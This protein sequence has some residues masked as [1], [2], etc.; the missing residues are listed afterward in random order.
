MHRPRPD[1]VATAE[2]RCPGTAAVLDWPLW[3]ILRAPP[4]S[5]HEVFRY[6]ERLSREAR[7]QLAWW[8][9][10]DNFSRPGEILKM[11]EILER[12]A[13]VEALTCMLL[14]CRSAWIRG[15]S[16]S[17]DEWA[18]YIYRCQLIMGFQ[19][20]AHGIGRP[21]WEV[22]ALRMM[23]DISHR[24]ARYFFPPELYRD[25]ASGLY[26]V[27][28]HY[29]GASYKDMSPARRIRVM[30]MAL[31]ADLG[32]DLKFAFNPVR[33]V[34]D[35]GTCTHVDHRAAIQQ[36]I[37]YFVWAWKLQRTHRSHREFPPPGVASAEDHHE[38][39]VEGR[40]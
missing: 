25:A 22:V 10:Q 4:Q 28:W 19:L 9:T 18:R 14:L 34:V 24:G 5:D 30:R 6:E 29:S 11:A 37:E 13:N 33:V 32:W 8:R 3:D 23:D 21:L 26:R 36:D 35:G 17:A 39:G 12:Q 7:A 15:D 38:Q 40:P 1:I 16:E 2:S 31:N 20:L 27:L